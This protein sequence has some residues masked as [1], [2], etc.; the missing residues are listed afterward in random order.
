MAT[1]FMYSGKGSQYYQMGKDLFDTDDTFREHLRNLDR[2]IQVRFKKSVLE[3]IYAEGKSIMDS[4]DDS[5][6]SGL[7]LML[8]ELAL[9]RTLIDKGLKPDILLGSSFGTI[10]ASI[11]ADCVDEETAIEFIIEHCKLFETKCGEGCMVAVLAPP[12]FYDDNTVLQNLSE[13][14][15]VNFNKSFVISMPE[16]N[17]KEVEK[18][19]IKAEVPFQRLPVRR[20]FHSKWIDNAKTDFM[21]LYTGVDFNTSRIPIVCTSSSSPLE[22]VNENSFWRVVRGPIN[23]QD[24]AIWFESRGPHTYI[25]LGPFGTLA[26]FLKY[27]LPTESASK[28]FPI[29]SPYKQS[30]KNMK[31]VLAAI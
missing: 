23:F 15:G 26:T 9:T 31:N 1:V 5:V 18:S 7:S 6:L 8:L 4:L 25:D 22:E 10:V 14:A 3:E 27:T 11:V 16:E 30:S 21:S 19:L 24:T 12:Q 20:A 17:F 29:L 13:M 28:I 2:S